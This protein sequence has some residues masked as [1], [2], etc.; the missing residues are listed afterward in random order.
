MSYLQET[1]KGYD[2]AKSIIIDPSHP[3]VQR[4]VDQTMKEWAKEEGYTRQQIER[5]VWIAI[6]AAIA[7]LLE[8]ASWRCDELAEGA[9][10]EGLELAISK[11]RP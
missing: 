7:G 3:H 8:D 11:V 2:Q 10:D 1:I 4:Y 5:A 9:F 6:S